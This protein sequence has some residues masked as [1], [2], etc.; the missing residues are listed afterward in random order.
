MEMVTKVSK[1]KEGEFNPYTNKTDRYIVDID[2]PISKTIAERVYKFACKEVE[3][4]GFPLSIFRKCEIYVLDG[5]CRVDD[6]NY[7]GRF[8]NVTVNGLEVVGIALENYKP[9]FYHGIETCTA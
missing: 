4:F 5:E 1:I 8:E 2:R 6:R 9:N 7:T 3:A